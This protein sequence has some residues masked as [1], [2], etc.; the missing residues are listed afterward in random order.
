MSY[1]QDI[2]VCQTLW[3]GLT[4][5]DARTFEPL[6]GSALWPPQYSE[7]GRRV[8]F[9]IRPEAHWSNGDAMTAMDF[10]R[11]WRRAIEPGT[12]DVYAE[13]I[14]NHIVGADEYTD[15][16][17]AWMNT[18][19]VVRR[20]QKGSPLKAE[21]LAKALRSEAGE[22]LARLLPIVIPSPPPGEQ[23]E[24]WERAAAA[25]GKV[26]QD[27][28]ALGDRLLDEHIAEME[29]RF[30]RVGM[31]AVDDQHVEVRLARPT[32]YLGDLTSFPTFMPIHASIELLREQYEGRP[33]GE[34]GV[35]AYDPQWTKPDYHK[36]GYPG[37]VTNGPY[38][39]RQWQFKRSLRFEANPRYWDRANVQSRTV[40]SV[41]IEYQN[42][43][44]I[45][46][47][48]GFADAMIDLH[49]DYTPEL[50]R[51]A[52]QGR[53]SDIHPMPTFGTYF[54]GFNCRSRLNDGQPNPLSDARV[55]RA[56]ARAVNKQE[57][58]DNVV[59]LGS[60]VSDTFI[61]PNQIPG[62]KSPRGLPY[63]PDLA[64]R[65][66]AEA[67]YPN[68]RGMP[69]IEYLYNTNSDQEAKT[70]AVARMWERE[71]G[72]RVQLK[73]KETKT[74]ADD[75]KEHRFMVTRSGWF[76]D[77][78]YP[79]TFLDLQQ[80]KNGQNNEGFDDPYYDGLLAKA[81]RTL[82]PAERLKI[83]S[84]AERYLVEEQLP[85]LPLFTYVM[86]YAWRP[87]V[88]GIYPNPRNQF[89]MQLIY[90]DRA[91]RRTP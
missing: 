76:G 23:D 8:V 22:P 84:E 2:Q 72:L 66:L 4:Q 57:L 44:F 17:K 16:R 62:Y 20:L 21:T 75:L 77:Y 83:L 65:E 87:E 91:A 89:P 59:R 73:G 51:L 46:Y 54:L 32:P 82:D 18:L 35:W 9:T 61:P 33:L 43:A 53:R 13:L 40:E 38:V 12:A 19:S 3:E 85:V 31:R 79:T 56:L 10:V 37:L 88:T 58:V 25:V 71:L 42:S 60:P 27:W 39:L 68:G 7:E 24:F 26:R 78:I 14:S 70:Q 52:R 69:I 36:S 15:W 64:R 55:R 80:S 81:S 29:P 41:D 48:Q 28:K 67:G 6:S 50:V 86:V 74:Y 49:M 47:D 45:L 90:V 5:L 30:A 1:F 34:T 11:G 63:D